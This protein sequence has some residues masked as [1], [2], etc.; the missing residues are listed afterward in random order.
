MNK[1]EKISSIRQTLKSGK[2]TI[3]SWIQLPD[4]STAEIMGNAGYDWIAVDMEHGSIS[5][6]SLP[7]IFRALELGGTLPIVR[8]AAGTIKDCKKALDAGACGVI[9]PMVESSKQLEEAR[10]ASCW[11]PSGTRGV[12]FSRA[13][14]FGKNFESYREL[15][16]QPLFLAMIENYKA[17]DDLDQILAVKGLDAVLIGPYD[18]SSS[19][20]ITAEFENPKFLDALNKIH[21]LCKRYKIPMGMHIVLSDLELLNKKFKEG[22]QF[23]AYGIDGVFLNAACTRPNL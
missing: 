8:L 23:I 22:Y 1:L 20:G 4:P 17:I 18:L 12:G 21:T 10:N 14:L 3:G 5:V 7:N 11:P 13:N 15:A 2:A 6:E 19:M 16:Q 9:I